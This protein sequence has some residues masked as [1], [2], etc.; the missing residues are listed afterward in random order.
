[1]PGITICIEYDPSLNIPL[2]EK[3]QQGFKAACAEAGTWRGEIVRDALS[4][5]NQALPFVEATGGP[6]DKYL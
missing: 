2:D 1:M 4:L 6:R 3:L 5:Q